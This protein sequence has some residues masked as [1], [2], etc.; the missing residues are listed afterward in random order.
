MLTLFHQE[1]I[2]IFTVA[3]RCWVAVRKLF[4]STGKERKTRIRLVPPFF[5][6]FQSAGDGKNKNRN[7]VVFNSRK[8]CQQFCKKNRK[9]YGF[10]F[11]VV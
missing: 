7:A 5:R 3:Q 11:L 10:R 6:G 2:F 9:G 1:Y 8:N 4:D